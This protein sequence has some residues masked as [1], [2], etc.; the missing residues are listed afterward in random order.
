MSRL[1]VLPPV[2]VAPNGARLTRADHPA[3]PVTIAETV[4]TAAACFAAGAGAIHAHVRDADGVHVLD[5]G[6]YA[7]LMAEL[8]RAVPDMAVQI[9]TESQGR[10]SPEEMRAAMR[11]LQPDGISVAVREMLAEGEDFAARSFY[12]EMV[13]RGIAV[14]HI[15][16]D[17]ADAARLCQLIRSGFLPPGVPQVLF[18]L[19]RYAVP[20]G[21]PPQTIPAFLDTLARGG[22]ARADWS[23]CAFG[24]RETDALAEAFRLGGKARVG[25]E[26]SLLRADGSVARDNAERVADIVAL[27]RTTTAF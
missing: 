16:F 3:I 22:V 11:G 25:F 6:L 14:Q 5:A 27:R 19:G 15:L 13:D 12:G 10:Y 4:A 20:E 18:V 8:A 7:E 2:M 21:V 23:V 1:S 17:T 9:T 26:N 24:V